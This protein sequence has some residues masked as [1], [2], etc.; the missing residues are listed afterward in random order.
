MRIA[1]VAIL[2]VIIGLPV[3]GLLGVSGSS[4]GVVLTVVII[5]VTACVIIWG[6]WQQNE[7]TASQSKHAMVH[8]RTVL[9][10]VML[11]SL[12]LSLTLG[13][14]LGWYLQVRQDMNLWIA[15]AKLSP[16]NLDLLINVWAGDGLSEAD[17]RRRLFDRAY[18]LARGL[19]EGSSG[20]PSTQF[21][22]QPTA[23]QP[24]VTDS[25]RSQT[26][27]PNQFPSVPSPAFPGRYAINAPTPSANVCTILEPLTGDSLRTSIET[28]V[29]TNDLD[30]AYRDAAD[31]FN[32]AYLRE[33]ISRLCAS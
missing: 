18:P 29:A 6:Y 12:S 4:T 3:G 14:A 20:I 13:S 24:T 19:P 1:G 22:T 30:V 17:V 33:E 25:S 27:Q 11:V 5:V 7:T 32:D 23:T 10:L 15:Q 31:A 26:T 8:M 2:L 9:A 21:S 28:F 16:D